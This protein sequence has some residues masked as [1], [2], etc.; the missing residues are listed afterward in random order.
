MRGGGGRGAAQPAAVGQ[1]AAHLSPWQGEG[2]AGGRRQVPV[3]AE[4][5]Q[6]RVDLRLII[7]REGD[8]GVQALSTD[9][10]LCVVQR[11][12]GGRVCPHDCALEIGEDHPQGVLLKDLCEIGW[13]EGGGEVRHGRGSAVI[14]C[15]A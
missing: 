11:L 7:G 2:V 14:V 3:A 9:L 8:E 4:G 10:R 15:V 12:A 5:L 13:E 1:K 6:A